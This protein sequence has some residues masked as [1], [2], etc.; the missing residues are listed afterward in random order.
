MTAEPAGGQALADTEE[1]LTVAGLIAE[2]LDEGRLQSSCLARSGSSTPSATGGTPESSSCCSASCQT[3]ILSGCGSAASSW[4]CTCRWSSTW[5]GGS[6]T[7]ASGS[8]T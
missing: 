4:S 1:V 6:A 7:G 8:T 2:E 3:V 5:P